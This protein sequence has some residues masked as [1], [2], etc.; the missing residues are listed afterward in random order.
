MSVSVS[1]RHLSSVVYRLDSGPDVALSSPYTVS[2]AS[3]S[4][5]T[6]T[7]Q[8]RATDSV[9]HTTTR[10]STFEI[11]NSSVTVSVL[12]PANGSV[13]KS[14]VPIVLSV[15][16]S[17]TLAC[18]WHEGGVSHVLAAPYAISTATWSEGIHMITII[19]SN[20]IGGQYSISY[21]VVIDNTAPTI[22]LL[23]PE[24]G[25]YV[26]R[27]VVVLF[28]ASDAHYDSVAWTVW[29]MGYESE[30][31]TVTVLLSRVDKDGLFT[32]MVTAVDHANN[33]AS[34]NFAFT[35]DS[36]APV[37]EFSGPPSGSAIAAGARLNVTATDISLLT[38]LLSID[39]GA[40]QTISSPCEIDTSSFSSGWHS[41]RAYATDRTG[42]SSSCNISVYVDSSA[43]IVQVGQL[44]R[45][46]AGSQMVITASATDDSEVA[47]VVLYYSDKAGNIYG[48]LMT[49]SGE[50]Y[51][52]TLSPDQMWD[53]IVVYAVATDS[54]GHTSESSHVMIT[55]H[56][57]I[58]NGEPGSISSTPANA[59]GVVSTVSIALAVPIIG[60]MLLRRRKDSWEVLEDEAFLSGRVLKNL[61]EDKEEPELKF[62]EFENLAKPT[63]LLASEV[64][65]PEMEEEMKT[66]EPFSEPPVSPPKPTPPPRA[67]VRLIDAIPEMRFREEDAEEEYEAFMDELEE[68]QKQMTALAEKHSVY[69]ELEDSA[70][71]GTDLDFDIDE[72]KPKRISGLQLKKSME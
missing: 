9:G 15:A 31:T 71:P 48:V 67:P 49:A 50:A 29:G 23:S 36:S 63:P 11:A 60:F 57:A 12:S 51:T 43:P 17:G 30:S 42:Q 70:R 24:L 44:G 21:S 22:T 27:S 62:E 55:S 3:W 72:T 26:N 14:G 53:G 7:V 54:V 46:E 28:R 18:E 16:G 19:A 13:I 58:D 47:S 35:M 6:H 64:E 65:E 8:V 4:V 10:T 45:F 20:N 37:I 5:G 39:D 32:V 52:A 56:G 1:D 61:E 59:L 2:M 34:A 40:G 68:V 25:S 66:P 38:F 69:R 41:L 33:T